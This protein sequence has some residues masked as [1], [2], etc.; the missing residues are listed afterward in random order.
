MPVQEE[1]RLATCKQPMRDGT[2]RGV[3][4]FM[5]FLLYLLVVVAS[6]AITPMCIK[7]LFTYREIPPCPEALLIEPYVITHA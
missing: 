6:D 2:K 7:V 5:E 1:P 3:T 4:L